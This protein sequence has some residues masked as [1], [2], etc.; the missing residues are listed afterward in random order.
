[1]SIRS[2]TLKDGSTVYDVRCSMGYRADG[3]IDRRC[4]TVRSLKQAKIEE[5]KMIA[6]RDANRGRS[7]RMTLNQYIEWTYWPLASKRLAATT[8]DTYDQEIRLRIKPCLGNKYIGEINRK[9]IQDMLDKCG[10]ESVAKKSLGVLTTILNEAKSDGIIQS[11]PA[12]A[13]YALPN[14]GSK[15][16]NGLVLTDFKQIRAFLNIVSQ[17]GSQSVQRIAY[18]GLL[19][20]LRPE[21]RYALNYDDIDCTKQ[22]IHVHSAYVQA[23]KKHGGNQEKETKTPKSTR[24]IPMHPDFLLWVMFIPWT[25]GAFIKGA[26]GERISPSTAQK[27]WRR[28]LRDNPD[29]P[30]VTIE[31][32]RHS[33]A[34]AYLADGGSIESLSKMLG[35]T[36]INTTINRY[37]RPDINALKSN[38]FWR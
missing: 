27:R 12:T 16:D 1:M 20:G 6:E 2:R 26:D 11:N 10:T 18:T 3:K 23:S 30:K 17:K 14:K 28:F 25:D 37:Y 21:E 24:T 19:Q 22:V 5:S 9:M 8:L 34:T 13:R 29:V 33:F 7:K 35:H 15:R 32:M 31:N 4:L 38:S 36:N